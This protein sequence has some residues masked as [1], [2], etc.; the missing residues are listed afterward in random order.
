MA[1]LG[2]GAVDDHA[3]ARGFPARLRCSKMLL[4]QR[5]KYFLQSGGKHL[6]PVLRAR[7]IVRSDVHRRELRSQ[8]MIETEQPQPSAACSRFNRLR[9]EHCHAQFRSRGHCIAAVLK[10]KAV[11]SVPATRSQVICATADLPA[12]PIC[13]ALAGS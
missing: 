5:D 6:S 4:A 7:P 1:E 11:L 8:R 2:K 10:P 12:S 3:P 13:R 9:V